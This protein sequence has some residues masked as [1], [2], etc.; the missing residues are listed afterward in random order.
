MFDTKTH[1]THNTLSQVEH[2]GWGLVDTLLTFKL[3]LLIS[4]WMLVI[5]YMHTENTLSK[6]SNNTHSE[7]SY[8]QKHGH[9]HYRSLS[10]GPP[11]CQKYTYTVHRLLYMMRKRD[12][13]C[14][15]WQID[16][17][18]HLRAAQQHWYIQKIHWQ[19]IE[20]THIHSTL[21]KTGST[22]TTVK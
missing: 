7:N 6:L 1:G 19:S 3:G 20:L 10:R 11:V 18:R 12:I 9:K 2:N 4:L 14:T 8:I 15:P 16:S 17:R 22:H 5:T 21:I 13:I